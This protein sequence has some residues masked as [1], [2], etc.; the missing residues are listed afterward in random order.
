[1]HSSPQKDERKKNA[2]RGRTTISA[3]GKEGWSAEGGEA[4]TE[5]QRT[6]CARRSE[7]GAVRHL[8]VDDWNA[9]STLPEVRTHASRGAKEASAWQLRDGA[10]VTTLKVLHPQACGPR[11]RHATASWLP[12]GRRG[13]AEADDPA[14][15]HPSRHH[16]AS[17]SAGVSMGALHGEPAVEAGSLSAAFIPRPCGEGRRERAWKGT[18]LSLSLTEWPLRCTRRWKF[19]LKPENV[20]P[21]SSH[22]SAIRGTQDR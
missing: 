18:P 1:V 15:S 20:V 19:P 11:S 9:A 16:E 5:D 12:R 14:A 2:A 17:V 10:L 6:I 21:L 4:C 13:W 7:E 3:R 22:A 8:G